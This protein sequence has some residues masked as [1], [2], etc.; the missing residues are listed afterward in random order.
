MRSQV[1]TYLKQ[2][3]LDMLIN[4]VIILNQIAPAMPELFDFYYFPGIV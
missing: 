4:P 1:W 2:V 3:C